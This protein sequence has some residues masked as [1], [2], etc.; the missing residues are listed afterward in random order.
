MTRVEVKADGHA[1]LTPA[2]GA[3]AVT[4]S[5]ADL[6]GSRGRARAGHVYAMTI[7][8]AQGLTVDRAIVIGNLGFFLLDRV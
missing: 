4:F 7:Y 3:E 2:I 1:R 5:T 6:V 8:N